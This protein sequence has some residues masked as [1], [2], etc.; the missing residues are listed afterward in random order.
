[1]KAAVIYWSGTGNTEMMANAIVEG[2]KEGGIEVE[3]F[4]VT[5]ITPEDALKYDA[6]ALGCPAM[7]DEVLEEYDFEPFFADLEKSLGGHKV[8]IFGSYSWNDGQWMRD[9][10]ARTEESGAVLLQT[11]GLMAYDTPN[12]EDLAKC[13][14]LG[15]S[16]K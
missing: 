8:A 1:M 7:G 9:W 16:L 5:E 11:E 4:E 15:K 13:K 14:E 12:D 10:Y 3:L 6:L 2:A